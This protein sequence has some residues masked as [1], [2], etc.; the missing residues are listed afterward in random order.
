MTYSEMRVDMRIRNKKTGL[1]ATIAA[2]KNGQFKIVDQSGHVE[3]LDRY[4]AGDWEQIR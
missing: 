4:Y 3:D 2:I 1:K